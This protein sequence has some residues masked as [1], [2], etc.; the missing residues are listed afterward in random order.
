MS[1]TCRRAHSRCCVCTCTLPCHV[2]QGAQ[3][4]ITDGRN[5]SRQNASRTTD[6][7]SAIKRNAPVSARERTRKSHWLL[8]CFPR[9]PHKTAGLWSTRGW[10]SAGRSAHDA[11]RRALNTTTDEARPRWSFAGSWYGEAQPQTL[12]ALCCSSAGYNVASAHP[13]SG[14]TEGAR[15][16]GVAGV[17]AGCCEHDMCVQIREGAEEGQTCVRVIFVGAAQSATGLAANAA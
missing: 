2:S 9:K 15:V 16:R 10:R 5:W 6:Q 1:R 13:T 7:Q 11:A 8:P 3:R 12:A 17:A 4:Q 14:T